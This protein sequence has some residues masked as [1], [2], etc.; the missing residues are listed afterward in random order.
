MRFTRGFLAGL[1]AAT[2]LVLAGS[3]SLLALSTVIAFRGWPDVRDAQ[4]GTRGAPLELAQALP[5]ST[6]AARPPGAVTMARRSKAAVRRPAAG[7]GSTTGAAQARARVQGPGDAAPAQRRVV[8]RTDDA[9]GG[10]AQR[11][12]TSGAR[13]RP[14]DGVRDTTV[15]LAGGVQDATGGLGDALQPVSP[16]LGETVTGVGETVGTT[17]HGVGEVAANVVDG[18]V[19]RGPRQP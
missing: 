4:A 1:G 15:P 7:S 12:E 5:A 13:R 6:V 8:V 3:L 11:D 18:L 9:G 14:A 19:G 10:H 17:V 2:S 16:S